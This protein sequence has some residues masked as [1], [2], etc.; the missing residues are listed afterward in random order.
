MSSVS[1]VIV[2]DWV[3][4]FVTTTVKVNRP[5]GAGRLSGFTVLSTWMVGTTAV[6]LTTASSVSVTVSPDVVPTPPTVTMSVCLSPALP[7]KVPSNEHEYEPVLAARM[8]PTALV[9][10]P[11]VAMFRRCRRSAR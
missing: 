4:G 6:M 11:L 9:Q 10:V 8:V 2:S 1:F 5:V 3:L 7:V